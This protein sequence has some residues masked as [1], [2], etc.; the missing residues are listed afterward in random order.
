M[1]QA[2]LDGHAKTERDRYN[3]AK[4]KQNSIETADRCQ[5]CGRGEGIKLVRDVHHQTGEPRG[6]VCTGCN[7]ALGFFRDDVAV[8]RR[9]LAYLRRFAVELST[10]ST[11]PPT[12][13]R[14]SLKELNQLETEAGSG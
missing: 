6:V 14:E 3:A 12:S 2:C 5:I 4:E 8:I 10:P 11:A 1:C 9:A 13:E 7:T